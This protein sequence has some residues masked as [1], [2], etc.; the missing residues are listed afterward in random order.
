MLQER[1]S[2]RD[3]YPRF[4]RREGLRRERAGDLV[5]AESEAGPVEMLAASLANARL[6]AGARSTASWLALR[7]TYERR[8][9]GH[10]RSRRRCES[11][12]VAADRT[13]LS[14]ATSLSGSAD[15]TLAVMRAWWWAGW[16]KF[17]TN[18]RRECLE[19]APEPHGLGGDVETPVAEA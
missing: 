3:A 1:R 6:E 4:C 17:G 15:G 7:T 2:G 8:S 5:R 11:V 18:V 19:H 13:S 9:P 12:L 16:F 10:A 14:Y